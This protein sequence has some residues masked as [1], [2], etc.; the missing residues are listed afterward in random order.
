VILLVDDRPD[1]RLM[2][3]LWLD[4]EGLEFDEAASGEEA[5]ERS[6]ERPYDLVLLD[7][8]MPPGMNGLEVAEA[9]RS[10]GQT[11]PIVLYSGY[12]DPAVL[13]RAR[14]MGLRTVDRGEPDRVMEA[15][16]AELQ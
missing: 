10:S 4:D 7:Q 5:L 15:V 3:S 1:M 2:L 9:M 16:R 13:A 14:E 8:R 11:M 6:G 12:L